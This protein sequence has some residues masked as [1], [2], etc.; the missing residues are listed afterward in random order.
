MVVSELA[1]L[2]G[3]SPCK[4]IGVTNHLA[5]VE[6]QISDLVQRLQLGLL[7]DVGFRLARNN[8]S[9][10]PSLR[11]LDAHQNTALARPLRR[12]FGATPDRSKSGAG[13]GLL[14]IRFL[15]Y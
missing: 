3:C 10:N 14:A 5:C 8:P 4:Q 2:E 13:F 1:S 15:G 11:L 7:P 9:N 12:H 6:D